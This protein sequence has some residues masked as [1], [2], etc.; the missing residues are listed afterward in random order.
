MYNKLYIHLAE[1]NIFFSEQ[2]GFWADHVT[3]HTIIEIVD[4]ITNAFIKNKHTM[5]VFID[6]LEASLH[7]KWSFPLK[8]QQEIW[9]ILQGV[10]SLEV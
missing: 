5:A 2:V 1:H 7:K 4:E 10:R 6:F 3:D 8:S 9:N